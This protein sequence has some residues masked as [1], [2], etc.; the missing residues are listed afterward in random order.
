ME[1]RE[2]NIKKIDMKRDH[3]DRLCL[4]WI[5]LVHP[6][7]AP[8]APRSILFYVRTN[9]T[10]TNRTNYIYFFGV[11]VSLSLCAFLSLSLSPSPS[12]P[13][14]AFVSFR[15]FSSLGLANLS[16]HCFCCFF[17][18]SSFIRNVLIV[19][20]DFVKIH[21]KSKSYTYAFHETFKNRQTIFSIRKDNIG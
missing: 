4:M 10:L 20:F 11:C 6:A 8:A 17:L 14:S 12:P 9:D 19:C 21:F 15:F 1:T 18:S 3:V 7:P 2:K 5:T 13:Q 16:V